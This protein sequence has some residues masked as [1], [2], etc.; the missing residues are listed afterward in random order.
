MT[1]ACC[2]LRTRASRGPAA[3][4]TA[5][6]LLAAC[7]EPEA[8]TST[9]GSAHVA[10]QIEG[11]ASIT[12]AELESFDAYYEQLDPSLGHLH[13]RSVILERHLLPLA[14][15]RAAFP[16]QRTEA[17]RLAEALRSVADNS[18]EL[19][20]KGA[21]AGGRVEGPLA[22][23]ALPI[24][25]AAWAVDE[26]VLG[27]VSPPLELKDAVIVAAVLELERGFTPVSDQLRLFVVSFPAHDSPEFAAW[28]AAEEARRRGRLTHCDPD[29]LPSLPAWLAR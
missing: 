14:L 21:V 25:L 1:I 28:L 4:V 5:L 23:S 24:P 13:R 12:R 27:A 6:V 20:R 9:P 7:R 22:R 8:P 18:L 29:L 17:R 11:G 2:D 15:A 3:A 19:Q 16:A 10:L 26:S